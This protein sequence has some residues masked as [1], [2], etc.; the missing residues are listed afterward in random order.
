MVFS[1]Q[2]VDGGG[3]RSPS[4]NDGRPAAGESLNSRQRSDTW[5]KMA[6][7]TQKKMKFRMLEEDD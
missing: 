1:V 6:I 4:R 5:L 3:L 7:Y 2:L